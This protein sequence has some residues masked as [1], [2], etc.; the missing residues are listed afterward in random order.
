VHGSGVNRFRFTE[1]G[2]GRVMGEG[3]C[4]HLHSLNS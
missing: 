4:G 1:F 3:D 2:N